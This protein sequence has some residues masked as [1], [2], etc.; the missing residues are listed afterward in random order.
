MATKKKI[1][2]DPGKDRVVTFSRDGEKLS[3]INGVLKSD[4]YSGIEKMCYL[5]DEYCAFYKGKKMGILDSNGVLIT[6]AEW[7]S[8]EKAGSVFHVSKKNKATKNTEYGIINLDGDLLFDP[9]EYKMISFSGVSDERIVVSSNEAGGRYGAFDLEGN[10]VIAPKFFSM[11]SFYHNL[12]VAT[13]EKGK[14]GLLDK[15]GNWALAPEYSSVAGFKRG[16]DELDDYCV[17]RKDERYY[18]IDKECNVVAGPVDKP[19]C[20]YCDHEGMFLAVGDEDKIGVVNPNGE[21][22]LPMEYEEVYFINGEYIRFMKNYRIGLADMKGN[23][24]LSDK[25]RIRIE[26]GLIVVND[27]EVI[28]PDGTPVCKAEKTVKVFEHVILVSDDNNFWGVVDHDGKVLLKK[29]WEHEHTF[30]KD[31]D[32]KGGFINLIRDGK[33]S[34][35]DEKG[36]IKISLDTKGWAFSDGFAIIGKKDDYSIINHSG[37]VV[38]DH[39][40]HV[41]NLGGGYFYCNNME[42]TAPKILDAKSGEQ[43]VIP[44]RVVS[45][46]INGL[47]KIQASDLKYG[48]VSLYTGKVVM[49]PVYAEVL[50]TADG[51]W[52]YLPKTN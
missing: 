30:L 50:L 27:N 1:K 44:A 21:T 3:E 2:F 6:P 14:I 28:K 10:L 41:S 15:N 26:H 46:S 51:I 40:A 9:S 20:Q 45:K 38:A 31:L 4:F 43:F 39:H 7:E 37:E 47:V 36:E 25:R 29:E 33:T 11:E 13:E 48:V 22:V 5:S 16:I 23:L 32:F 42:R 12:S 35:V 19:I 52:G 49:E 17:I 34:Y 18:L 24:L 8:I